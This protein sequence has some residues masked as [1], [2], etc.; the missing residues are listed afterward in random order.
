MISDTV[1][2]VLYKAAKSVGMVNRLYYNHNIFFIKLITVFIYTH[3]VI[4]DFQLY[5]CYIHGIFVE[6]VSIMLA[7][8][9][10]KLVNFIITSE[11]LGYNSH[12]ELFIALYLSFFIFW[13]QLQ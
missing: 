9:G 11:G 5:I 2:R 1:T 7:E 3:T 13:F 4:D 6:A 8:H 10:A 12:L